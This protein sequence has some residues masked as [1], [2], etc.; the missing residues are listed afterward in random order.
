[1][2]IRTAEQLSDKLSGDL[3]W[4]KKELSEI[5]SLVEAK[6]VSEQRHKALLRSGVC[7]LYSH[8]EG[9]V[10]L[11]AN[12]YLEYVRSKK[13]TY[14]ELS[15]NFLALAMKEKLKEAKE[16]NK[17]SLYIPVC[18][19]FLS[20]LNQRCILPKD[21]IST[22]LNLSSEILKEITDI[23]GI[24]FSLYSTKSVLID[25]KLLKTRNEIAHGNYSV[26]DKGEYIE[27]HLEVIGMLDI[28]RN[29][30]ENAAIEK[31]FM[32]ISS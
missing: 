1:M 23:L 2:S 30:I 19:F 14:K 21:A 20:E 17:P 25:T 27:L 3:A 32:Q 9:F 7:I 11:A 26:F 15:S 29:Q 8:W 6:N 31:K 4:R 24:D 16:T 28:F 13:L 5:K 18:D 12:S 10:K 22:A